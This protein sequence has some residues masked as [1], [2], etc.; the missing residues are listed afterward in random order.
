MPRSSICCSSWRSRACSPLCSGPSS[1]LAILV[2]RRIRP[3]SKWLQQGPRNAAL[4]ACCSFGNSYS[5]VAFIYVF[6]CISLSRSPGL[7]EAPQC[8][9]DHPPRFELLERSIRYTGFRYIQHSAAPRKG[10]ESGRAAPDA[11]GRYFSHR[12]G[13]S[14]LLLSRLSGGSPFANAVDCS[15]GDLGRHC[16]P[17]PLVPPQHSN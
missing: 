15:E 11:E 16:R 10:Q 6:P 4:K 9:R 12:F 1:G 3:H 14:G 8:I 13:L 2:R 17:Q 7:S 5:N